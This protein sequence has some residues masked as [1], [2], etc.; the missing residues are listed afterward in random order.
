MSAGKRIEADAAYKPS[1]STP[2]CKPTDRWVGVGWGA[3]QAGERIEADAAYEVEPLRS[4]R[5]RSDDRPSATSK[6]CFVIVYFLRFLIVK[7][8]VK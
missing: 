5:G 7:V 2:D 6:V 4:K 3:D 8:E 1:L